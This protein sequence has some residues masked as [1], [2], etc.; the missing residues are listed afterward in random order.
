MK[1]T[2]TEKRQKREFLRR[3]RQQ[4]EIYYT[5]FRA[6][7]NRQYRNAARQYE[8]T[9]VFNPDT[10]R[11]EDLEPTYRRLYTINTIREAS[12]EWNDNVVPV[13]KEIR[14]A[15]RSGMQTKDLID[16]LAALLGFGGEGR[17][18]RLWRNLLEQYLNL[19]ILTRIQQVTDTTRD[20]LARII[21]Q[22]VNEG[23]SNQ[24]IARKIR[25]D[26]G[27]NKSRA[28]N[29]ARTEVNTAMNQ[30]KYMSV[31]SSNLVYEKGWSATIDS[32]TRDTHLAM[33]DA[34]M[35][36]LQALFVVGGFNM[37]YPGDSSH[38]APAK[39]ICNCRCSLV[40]RVK[41][42]SEGRPIRKTELMEVR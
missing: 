35:I 12:I 28:M 29:I 16:D 36:D 11:A 19:R 8:E 40:F 26:A 25:N 17:I 6:I 13:L 27:M 24:N 14:K 41:R 10:I 9:G 30:G 31:L 21:E 23:L 22:G 5:K 20:R 37:E 38:G 18:V 3:H 7:L 4:E 33:I 2:S 1:L 15:A 32:R 42:D 39:E 34:E